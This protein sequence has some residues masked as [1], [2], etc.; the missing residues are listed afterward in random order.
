MKKIMIFVLLTALVLLLIPSM[1]TAQPD[2]DKPLPAT[3]VELVKKITLKGSKA[4]GGKP[5]KQAASGVLG[6]ECNGNRYAI[7]IGISNYPGTANDLEYGDDDAQDMYDALTDSY[8]FSS[9]NITM[10]TDLEASFYA[11]QN[12]IAAKKDQVTASDEVVFFFSGHGT[13]GVA[14]DSDKENIDEAI[15][16]HDGT[17][18]GQLL[19]IWDG[20]LKDWFAGFATERIIF[21][22]DSCLS[23]GMTDLKSTGRVICMA[24]SETGYSYEGDTWGNGQFTYYFVDQGISGSLADKYDHDENPLTEDVTVEEAF[25]YA[26][27]NCVLQSPGIS[28]SFDKDLLP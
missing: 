7:V 27:T 26:K 6:A 19:A 9:A 16:C 4:A 14:M 12:A 10:L 18:N 24:S 1:A 22:F 2:K 15:V 11:I 3:N 28:D 13:K 17:E 21:I 25:D 8:K 5:V 23:G 20:Q